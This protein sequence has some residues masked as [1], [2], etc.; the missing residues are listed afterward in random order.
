MN[1]VNDA[2]RS[3]ASQGKR[4]NLDEKRK[5]RYGHNFGGHVQEIGYNEDKGR[6]GMILLQLVLRKREVE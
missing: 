4:S 3:K 6:K 1:I 2:K 5:Y